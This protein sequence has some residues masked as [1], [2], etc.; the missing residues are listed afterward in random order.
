M[1]RQ[2]REQTIANIIRIYKAFKNQPMN[3]RQIYH[4]I[5]EY[6]EQI[7]PCVTSKIVLSMY[8]DGLLEVVHVGSRFT[9][10]RLTEKGIAKGVA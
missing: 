3:H 8:Q 2:E 5:G 6:Q 1:N 4:H 7:S 10:Y 9:D